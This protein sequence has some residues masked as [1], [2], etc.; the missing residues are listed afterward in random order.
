MSIVYS[1]AGGIGTSINPFVVGTDLIYLL[2]DF[3][4]YIYT[5]DVAFLPLDELPD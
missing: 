2:P 1:S 3:S 5:Y 4:V